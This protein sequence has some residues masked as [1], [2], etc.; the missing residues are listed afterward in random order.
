MM[1]KEFMVGRIDTIA[2]AQRAR[3]VGDPVK[4][5]EY[6][7]AEKGAVAYRDAGFTG[8]VPAVVQSWADARSWTAEQAAQ[9]ILTEAIMF[10][11]ALNI[12]RGIRLS[13]KYALMAEG[14]TDKQMET[15]Y[16]QAINNLKSI[17]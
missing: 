7:E 3:L 10:H 6:L 14:L 13:A 5:F 11:M 12:I 8:T 4:A 2:D 16:Y 9:D 17:G 15:I 1:D